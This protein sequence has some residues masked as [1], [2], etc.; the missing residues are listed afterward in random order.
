MNKWK[1]SKKLIPLVQA[2][3]IFHI[4]RI[5]Q[6]DSLWLK[7]YNITVCGKTV[8]N[9]LNFIIFQH[10]YTNYNDYWWE[11]LVIVWLKMNKWI[12]IYTITI[13]IYMCVCGM[14]AQCHIKNSMGNGTISKM[15]VWSSFQMIINLVVHGIFYSIWINFQYQIG[16]SLLTYFSTNDEFELFLW[17][18]DQYTEKSTVFPRMPKA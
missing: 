11:C 7:W 15:I 3:M 2:L 16:K 13:Y 18:F 6:N 9:H 10:I 17:T 5:E 14:R 4:F 1:C 8:W 12:K